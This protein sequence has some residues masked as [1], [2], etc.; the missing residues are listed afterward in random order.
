MSLPPTEEAF[1]PNKSPDRRESC[2]I[3]SAPQMYHSVSVISLCCSSEGLAATNMQLHFLFRSF[4]AERLL[5]WSTESSSSTLLFLFFF[6]F[7]FFSEQTTQN[8]KTH[9]VDDKR[10]REKK[11]KKKKK[12]GMALFFPLLYS[13]AFF[14]SIHVLCS[15]HVL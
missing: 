11:E 2:G 10:R 13:L 5:C 9:S 14:G 7:F 15:I 8:L 6:L 1:R 3:R 4:H 12:G